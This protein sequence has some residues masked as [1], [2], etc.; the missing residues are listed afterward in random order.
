VPSGTTIWQQALAAVSDS[1][2]GSAAIGAG[3][4]A[5]TNAEHHEHVVD[6]QMDLFKDV[7]GSTR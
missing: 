5:V 6:I 7:S 4:K 1:P 2:A 3:L